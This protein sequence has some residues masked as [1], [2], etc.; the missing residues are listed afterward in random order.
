MKST[1]L[2]NPG[3]FHQVTHQIRELVAYAIS[4]LEI[5]EADGS[6]PSGKFAAFLADAAAK[7]PGHVDGGTS[8]GDN[9]AV[10][11]DGQVL[12]VDGH[13]VV[14]AVANSTITGAALK[15]TNV[16]ILKHGDQ[17]WNKIGSRTLVAQ[18]SLDSSTVT[19]VSTMPNAAIVV[20]GGEYPMHDQGGHA[21]RI[22]AK[23][24]ANNVTDMVFTTPE[25]QIVRNG[26]SVNCLNRDGSYGRFEIAADNSVG[27]RLNSPNFRVV[28][29]GDA[30]R[31][32][33]T[34]IADMVDYSSIDSVNVTLR[35]STFVGSTRATY[36]ISNANSDRQFHGCEPQR[37]SLGHLTLFKLPHNLCA[38]NTGDTFTTDDNKGWKVSVANGRITNLESTQ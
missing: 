36:A 7:C 38:L 35:D 16:R 9:Q 37:D 14:V 2:L 18:L 28:R 8:L 22:T 26:A 4:Q 30:V 17:C 33:G 3:D 5:A 21:G 24:T 34:I 23:V 11:E 1:D 10:I 27:Y 19:A 12:K 6:L 15:A 20:E 29:M 13:D 31:H 25:A 32:D